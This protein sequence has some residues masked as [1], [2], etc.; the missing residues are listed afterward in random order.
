MH[1]EIKWNH[2]PEKAETKMK[3]REAFQIKF[4]LRVLR[5]HV[6][7]LIDMFGNEGSFTLICAK[8]FTL[9]FTKTNVYLVFV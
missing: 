8:L 2:S 5:I 6:V 9:N 4:H 7:H 3:E 1:I